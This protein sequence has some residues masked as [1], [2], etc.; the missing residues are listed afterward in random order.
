MFRFN[1]IGPMS[2]PS[3]IGL[4]TLYGNM[5]IISAFPPRLR[6]NPLAQAVISNRYSKTAN[7]VSSYNPGVN[8]LVLPNTY[9]PTFIMRYPIPAQPY[10]GYNM[11]G[12]P[13]GIMINMNIPHTQPTPF[14]I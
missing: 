7:M 8:R 14:M 3:V 1:N 9:N 13:C 4:Y 11:Q 12:K 6:V 5:Q 10:M 2:C